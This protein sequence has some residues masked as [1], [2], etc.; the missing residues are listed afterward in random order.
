MTYLRASRVTVSG[1]E[2]Y[3][4]ADGEITG[5]ER[6]RSWQVLPAAYSMVLP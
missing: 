3:C 2:F 5:P 1:D 6:R 4:A